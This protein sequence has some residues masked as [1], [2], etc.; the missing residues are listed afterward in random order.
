MCYDRDEIVA[1]VDNCSDID[2]LNEVCA[3]F[4]Y[5]IDENYQNKS[6]HIRV[7]TNNRFK[8]LT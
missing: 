3:A 4:K 5:L 8:E 1:I 7:V 6:L 2:Q